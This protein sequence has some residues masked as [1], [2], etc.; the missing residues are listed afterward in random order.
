MFGRN[1]DSSNPLDLITSPND[2]GMNSQLLTELDTSD[3]EIPESVDD[4][5]PLTKNA[6]EWIDSIYYT[7]KNG[8]MTAIQNIKGNQEV[9]KKTYDLK[10]KRNR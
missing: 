8:K 10:V 3:D 7:R 2:T 9:Q 4:P 5:H 1:F 6:D